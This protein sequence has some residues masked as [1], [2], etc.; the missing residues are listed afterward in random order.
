MNCFRAF[1]FSGPDEGL[2]RCW[3]DMVVVVVRS[4]KKGWTPCNALVNQDENCLKLERCPMVNKV[5]ATYLWELNIRLTSIVH[6]VY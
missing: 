3:G 2:G 5:Q 1:A 4:F 6:L